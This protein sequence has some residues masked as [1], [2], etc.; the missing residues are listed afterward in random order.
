MMQARRWF[1]AF[2]AAKPPRMQAT[3]TNGRAYG[4]L[5]IRQRGRGDRKGQGAD[6]SSAAFRQVIAGGRL[7]LAI[8]TG[9]LLIISAILVWFGASQFVPGSRLRSSGQRHDPLRGDAFAAALQGAM[10]AVGARRDAL[11]WRESSKAHVASVRVAGDGASRSDAPVAAL[12]RL[13]GNVL[14][15]RRRDRV[16]MREDDSAGVS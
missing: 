16:L 4:L 3:V 10:G 9:H 6:K 13:P 14:F 12:P 7:L 1:R 5:A 11:Y 2:P 15:D 8:R